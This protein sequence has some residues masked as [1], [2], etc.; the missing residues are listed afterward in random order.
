[1]KK[2]MT[3]AFTILLAASVSSAQAV[4]GPP[5]PSEPCCSAGDKGSAAKAKGKKGGMNQ[6]PDGAPAASTKGK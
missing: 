2:F 5:K 4:G 3:L 6:P 1:M